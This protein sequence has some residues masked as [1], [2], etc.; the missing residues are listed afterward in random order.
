MGPSGDDDDDDDEDEDVYQA[1]ASCAEGKAFL[2][3]TDQWNQSVF[4]G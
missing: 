3:K 1:I 4:G 2:A